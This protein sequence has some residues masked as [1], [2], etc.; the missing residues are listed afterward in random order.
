MA[1]DLQDWRACCVE[2]M[3]RPSPTASPTESGDEGED[4]IPI[5]EEEEEAEDENPLDVMNCIDGLMELA[6]QAAV[7]GDDMIQTCGI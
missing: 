3:T 2:W 5:G 7:G 1:K 6:I 4:G